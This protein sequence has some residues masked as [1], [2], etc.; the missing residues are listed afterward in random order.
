MRPR[1][2]PF[3]V[4]VSRR[5]DGM[6]KRRCPG[7]NLKLRPTNDC[8]QMQTSN[9]LF[10][11]IINRKQLVDFT[12]AFASQSIEVAQS[13]PYGSLIRQT[14]GSMGGRKDLIVQLKTPQ[15]ACAVPQL[16]LVRLRPLGSLSM[17]LSNA[18]HPSP[19]P[20]TRF[21][22]RHASYS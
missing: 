19:K 18:L 16:L 2:M 5:R 22:A 3:S 20:H 15:L 4:Y 21:L 13:R 14:S 9:S 11:E 12:R 10:D 8:Y 1:Q 7:F 17:P 6:Q